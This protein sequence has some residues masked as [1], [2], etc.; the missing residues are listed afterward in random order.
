MFWG[1][2]LGCFLAALSILAIPN[3]FISKKEEMSD[4]FRKILLYQGLAGLISF[5]AGII[6]LIYYAPQIIE[7]VAV[8]WLTFMMCAVALAGFG[9][10]LIYNLIFML[11]L[12]KGKKTE[13]NHHKM[14]TSIM[15]LQGKL[16][17]LGIIIG[18]WSIMATVMFSV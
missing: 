8:L 18:V 7:M 9:F 2:L 5:I 15:P 3:L 12:S 4:F 14:T 16:S 11:F 1:I 17:I 6:A 13:V 10:L